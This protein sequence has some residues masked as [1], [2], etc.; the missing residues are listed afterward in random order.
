MKRIGHLARSDLE[1]VY[2]GMRRN[3][4]DTILRRSA[5]PVDIVQD[6]E[7]R[8]VLLLLLLFPDMNPNCCI[9]DISV[10]MTCMTNDGRDQWVS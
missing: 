4:G 5:R 9:V 3:Q 6:R 8:D 1:H 2:V 10:T 7:G